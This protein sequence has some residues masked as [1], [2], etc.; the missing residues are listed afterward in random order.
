MKINDFVPNFS[1]LNSDGKKSSL[2]DFSD[3]WIVIYFY[4]KDNTPGCT[5]EALDFTKLNSEFEK[6]NCTI[7]GISK[8]SCES[9]LKFVNERKLSVILLSDPT[10]EVQ[11]MFDVWKPK[12]FLGK[13]YLGT[14]RSTFL[15][16]PNRKIVKIWDPVE[17]I[18]HAN[19]VL[20]F[21]REFQK[22]SK[23]N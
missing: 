21:L 20:A 18:G 10:A 13:E 14:V 8:D 6:S 9:H 17:P 12:K 11:K 1:L 16:D 5:I 15:L 7:L 22:E 2:A 4:P 19:E 3:R 23:K